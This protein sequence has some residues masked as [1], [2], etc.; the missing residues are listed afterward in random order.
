MSKYNI[1]TDVFETYVADFHG[2]TVTLFEKQ[3][4]DAATNKAVCYDCHGIHAILPPD[5][6]ESTIIK[7]NLLKTCQQCHPDATTNFPDSWTGHY[8]P[9]FDKQPLVGAVNLF[10]TIIIPG[11]I[12]FMGLF[13]ITDAGRRLI[14]RVRK[15]S[16]PPPPPKVESK[17]ETKNAKSTSSPGD[18]SGNEEGGSK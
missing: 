10:Y 18:K 17:E 7:E 11:T 14:G 1:S 4:P 8:P 16:P 2:T 3:S 15:T 13:V 9:T 5:D 6:P 12:G